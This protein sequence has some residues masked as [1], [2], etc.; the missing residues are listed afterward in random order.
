MGLFKHRRL[1]WR[2]LR[3]KTAGSDVVKLQEF[4]R[5]QGYDLGEEKDYGY[6]TKDAV[7]QFQRDHGLVADGIAGPRFFALILQ[8]DLPVR[9]NV[10]IVQGGETA[11]EI[12]ACYGVGLS[13]LT[14]LTEGG[15]VYPGQ[16]LV[17]FD[18]EV[19]GIF[20]SAKANLPVDSLT[21][22]ILSPAADE[23]VDTNLAA[24]RMASLGQD[25]GILRIHEILGG[26]KQRKQAVKDAL[27]EARGLAG[28]YLPWRQVAAPDGRRYL[29]FLKALRR[30]LDQ[31][32]LLTE[33]GPGVSPWRLWG[34]VDYSRVNDLADRVVLSL[35]IDD[36]PGSI[37]ERKK[38]AELLASL[39]PQIH[40]WKIL[41]RVPVFAV[42]W[43]EAAGKVSWLKLPYST[44]LSRAFRYGARLEEDE[45]GGLF[46]RYRRR[47]S[48]FYL[49]LPQ[50][51][52]LAGI[53]AL[54][55]L[56]NLAGVILD[57]LGMEDP[58]IWAALK[59]HFRA[60]KLKF[61]E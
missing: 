8:K 7:R 9:R 50:Y 16:R 25:D 6:L 4:L 19:W 1:G 32:M 46:Y 43:E 51:N 18:R 10:H 48:R 61:G 44:G 20:K 54:A 47:D 35:P 22:L 60:A 49:Y 14:N 38:A 21:G 11:A 56:Y 59:D 15:R 30:A 29:S 52:A 26:R 33:L 27:G 13:A 23:L 57:E 42:E 40:S 34:G 45:K 3:F 41:L 2:T 36:A 12:A 5:Q 31:K 53:F 17:F 28:F 39:L 37:V 58:R 24:V 55:N